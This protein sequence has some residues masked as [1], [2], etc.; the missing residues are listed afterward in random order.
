MVAKD[1]LGQEITVGRLVMGAD[2]KGAAIIFGEVVSIHGK[3][4]SPVIDIKILMNGPTV[5]Q[6]IITHQGVIKKNLKITK[7]VKDA[8]HKFN[9]ETKKWEWVEVINEYPYIIALSKE[10]EQTIRERVNKEFISLQNSSFK[11]CIDRNN[12]IKDDTK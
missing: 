12:K 9:E 11:E 6:T 3:E 8:S 1:Y 5:D 4:E 7:F 2:S 10:Q